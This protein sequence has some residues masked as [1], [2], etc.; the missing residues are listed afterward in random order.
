MSRSGRTRESSSPPTSP[1]R[2]PRTAV[3]GSVLIHAATIV[4]IAGI[5]LANFPH[6]TGIK[7]YTTAGHQ[8]H[9]RRVTPNHAADG[10]VV[11]TSA[12]AR[13]D[14]PPPSSSVIS[15]VYFFLS[16]T[17][18]PRCWRPHPS[19]IALNRVILVVGV[20]HR[21]LSSSLCRY[22]TTFIEEYTFIGIQSSS[23]SSS[24][25]RTPPSR[26]VLRASV[27]HRT[28]SSSSPACTLRRC[29]PCVQ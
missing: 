16:G 8:V 20:L 11:R 4:F 9:L 10:S 17:L 27:L 25:V 21:P 28:S 29:A 23:S 3:A 14:T 2:H 22:T 15:S 7:E 24:P 6:Q 18:H 1:S 19:A 5:L 26:C 12:S 13:S